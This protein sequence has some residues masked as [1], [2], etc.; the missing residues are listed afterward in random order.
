MKRRKQTGLKR[1]F[2]AGL[3]ST[4]IAACGGGG[5][6]TT[7]PPAGPVPSIGGT[8]GAMS[9]G[10]SVTIT[11]SSFGSKSHAGP[12]IY[13]D[14]DNAGA[15]NIDGREPQVHQGI[16]ASYAAWERGVGGTGAGN[17]VRDNSTLKARS[18]Y[19]ARAVFDNASF[20]SLRLQVTG[21]SFGTGD[22]RY[23]SFYYRYTRTSASY[24]KQTKAWIVFP[25][26]SGM[27]AA[28]WS[29]AFDVCESDGWRK[30]LTQTADEQESSLSGPELDGE[31]VR[32]E[33]W[34][35]LSAPNTA[36]GAWH[37]T[38]YRPT[39]GTPQK[40]ALVWND[41]VMRTSAENWEAWEFGGAFW[42]MCTTSDT[43]TVDIDEFYMD[44]TP[45]R[46]EVC[47]AP[48][49][50]ASTR[51]ELQRATTWSDSSITFIFNQGYLDSG[52]AYVYVINPSG[53]VNAAGH[54]ATIP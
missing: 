3:F 5:D 16:F 24:A 12:A 47:N 4:L 13:D 39:L 14:F 19:H 25:E 32:F 29:T 7:P 9:H 35:K 43:G 49:F 2:A 17:I 21:D 53:G 15:A 8:L 33:S 28:Y 48:T 50:S 18:T 40:D 10:G 54:E 23:I 34:L 46:V 38:T 44:S 1:I 11:G 30:H 52:L 27:D 31:W 45:A 20:W 51:C 36:N 26:G 42:D 37:Q 6:S 22:E 41:R